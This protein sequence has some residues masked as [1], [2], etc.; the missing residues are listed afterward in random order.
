MSYYSTPNA[1]QILSLYKN[2]V[3]P[4]QAEYSYFSV[5]LID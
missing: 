1:H 5:D 4:V 3:L 2:V